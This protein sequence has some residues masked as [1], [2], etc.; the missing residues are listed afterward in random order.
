MLA[1]RPL[2]VDV[3][4]GRRGKA[5]CLIDEAFNLAICRDIS[6]YFCVFPLLAA[7]CLADALVLLVQV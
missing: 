1:G 2:R 6:L 5:S 3:A 4:S 7:L